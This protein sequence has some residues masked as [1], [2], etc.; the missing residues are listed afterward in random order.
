MRIGEYELIDHGIEHSQYFQGCG[1][2]FTSYHHCAT[3][4]GSNF[5]DAYNDCCEMIAQSHDVDLE[6][7]DA[8]VLRDV[9]R[10]TFPKRPAVTRK[11]SDEHY[12]HVSI[13]FNLID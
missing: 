9:K 12:Y 5:E 4:I 6:G 13:R 8:R 3:G 7:F 1:V 11:H 2:A 10:R